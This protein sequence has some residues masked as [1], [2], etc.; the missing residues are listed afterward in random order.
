[1]LAKA[2]FPIGRG[3]RT[4]LHKRGRWVCYDFSGLPLGSTLSDNVPCIRSWHEPLQPGFAMQTWFSIINLPAE[5]WWCCARRQWVLCI[6]FPTLMRPW[7]VK[8]CTALASNRLRAAIPFAFLG[9]FSGMC[10]NFFD[11]CTS[12]W[13][14]LFSFLLRVKQVVH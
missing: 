3:F 8:C 2:F 4:F 14:L 5:P 12:L 11:K 10:Q 13:P 1:M 9:N 6:S 7:S